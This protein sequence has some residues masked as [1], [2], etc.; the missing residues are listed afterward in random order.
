MKISTK[1][2]VLNAI[3]KVF[4][5]PILEKLLLN[6]T[7][8]KPAD[9]F[10][11]KLIPNNY[12]YAPNTYRF[13]TRNGINYK[14][15]LYDYIGWWIYFGLKEVSRIRLYKL[16]NTNNTI[17]DVGT[18]IGE[19]LMNFA[20]RTLPGGE[21]HGFEPDA[22]NHRHCSENLHLNNFNN[23]V[24]NN[25]GLGSEAGQFYIKT[26]TPSNRGGNKVS[27]EYIENNT[28]VIKIITLDQYVTQKHLNKIDLIKIDVEGYEL[29]VLKGASQAIDKFK[30]VFFIELDDNN[31]KEQGHSAKALI[32]FLL[33]RNY[34]IRNSETDQM[35]NESTDFSN[36]HYDIICNPN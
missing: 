34:S 21:V 14:V 32:H 15:D 16:S 2:K 12:Q 19:T 13:V 17:I 1:T 22:Q 26:N 23:I 20:K 9:S 33:E 30:P 11:V 7:V 35:V 18:N 5:I 25:L 3:R 24:L 31:L 10:F 29:H 28:N 27:T 8:N 6:F 4:T 36:C